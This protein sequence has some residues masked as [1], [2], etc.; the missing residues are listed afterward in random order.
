[1]I[2]TNW[3]LIATISGNFFLVTEELIKSSDPPHP[4][5]RRFELQPEFDDANNQ[6]GRFVIDIDL[7]FD[8]SISID[9]NELA[10]IGRDIINFYCEFLSFLSGHPVQIVKNPE[11]TYNYPGTKKFRKILFPTQKAN[12]IPPTPL[13]NSALLSNTID[14]KL[15]RILALFRMGISE[16]DVYISF[17]LLTTALD[18]VS[19][20]YS[21][22]GNFIRKCSK[23]GHE[24]IIRPGIKQK[25][26]NL[27][28]NELNYST[29]KFDAIWET[30]NK[31]IH[32]GLDLSSETRRELHN[33]RM[34]V[35]LAVVKSIKIILNLGSDDPPPETP[36]HWSFSDALLDVEYTEP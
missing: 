20:F 14:P 7:S 25:V 1:M 3:K 9:K 12:L 16:K 18:L 15:T 30:R 35:Q 32:G 6:T 33:T 13:F 22:E 4:A 26:E 36:P 21:F 24:E 5:L 29:D 27:L 34:D 10:D 19:N 31:A 28:V 23:C 17:V 2:E 8:S 11:L